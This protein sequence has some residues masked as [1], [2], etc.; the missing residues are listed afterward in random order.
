MTL[1]VHLNDSSC[2]FLTYIHYRF[3]TC[4]WL[5]S[6]SSHWWRSAR[7]FTVTGSKHDCMMSLV[8]HLLH[9]LYAYSCLQPTFLHWLSWM[10]ANVVLFAWLAVPLMS[11]SM[12]SPSTGWLLIQPARL[13]RNKSTAHPIP[14]KLCMAHLTMALKREMTLMLLAWNMIQA[15]ADLSW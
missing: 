13:P 7:A 1:Y 9:L 11:L 3:S 6:L 14:M 2:R 12:L 8:V 15:M 5:F 4:T 10:D